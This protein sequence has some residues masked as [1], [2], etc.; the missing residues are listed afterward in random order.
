LEIDAQILP[1]IG[2]GVK[3]VNIARTRTGYR[4]SKMSAHFKVSL[5]ALNLYKHAK[6]QLFGP[7][8]NTEKIV[9]KGT[10]RD[11]STMFC[12]EYL[13]AVETSFTDFSKAPHNSILPLSSAQTGVMD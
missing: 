4:I 12:I 6:N 11:L 3:L 8:S 1:I 5:L 10:V 9:G 7:S 2:I 13:T